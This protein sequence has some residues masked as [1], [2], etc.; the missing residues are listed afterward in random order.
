MTGEAGPAA[1][2]REIHEAFLRARSSVGAVVPDRDYAIA[3]RDVR[4]SFATPALAD[5][6]APAVAHLQT[7]LAPSPALTICAFDLESTGARLPPGPWPGEAATPGAQW[8]HDGGTLRLF[9]RPGEALSLFD[10]S[11]GL[12]IYCVPSA[13]T[14]PWYESGSPFRVLLHWWSGTCRRRLV[15]AGAVGSASGVV[16]VGGKA[17]SGKSTTALA[18]LEA[19]LDYLGDDY[20]MV[21]ASPPA[22]VYSLYG[23]AK[24][25]PGNV[26]RFPGLAGSVAGPGGLPPAEKVLV[27]LEKDYG[28]RLKPA[29]PLRAIVVPRITGRERPAVRLMSPA[30]ALAALAPSTVFQ[31]PGDVEA[32]LGVV[33]GLVRTVPAY[34]LEL[35]PDMAGVPALIAELIA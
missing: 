1:Y 10:P 23:V 27:F 35:G 31:L 17:G 13:R 7:T 24:L 15:H 19:G 20:V 34:V 9:N 14:L 18:C 30:A 28:R 33:A 21:S 32:I 22:V 16:L 3:G 6:L 11:L 12:G 2:F 29:R 8:F 26:W 4:L 5:K 25:D